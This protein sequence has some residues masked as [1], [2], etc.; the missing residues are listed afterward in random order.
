MLTRRL[1]LITSKL[2]PT[3]MAGL[4]F[5]ASCGHS[6][7]VHGFRLFAWLFSLAGGRL[8]FRLRGCIP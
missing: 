7:V 1:G 2:H 6:G 3:V 8:A 5:F 4:G